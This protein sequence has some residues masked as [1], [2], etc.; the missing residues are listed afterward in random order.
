MY[1]NIRYDD[2]KDVDFWFEQF[3]SQFTSGR[4]K[5]EIFTHMINHG[6]WPFPP[7][8]IEAAFA[9]TLGATERIGTPYHLIEGTHRVSYLRRMIQLELVSNDD[10]VAI[11]EVID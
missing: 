9:S 6:E 10:S 3:D 2:N 4:S 8:I 11:I 1:D 7:V 5:S